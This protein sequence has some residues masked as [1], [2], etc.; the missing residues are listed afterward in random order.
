M[1]ETTTTSPVSSE[2]RP[3]HPYGGSQ[4]QALEACPC[5]RSKSSEHERTIAGTI[6]HKSVETG[7][8]DA[9]LSDEDAEGVAECL[10]LVEQRR[11]HFAQ[12][13]PPNTYMTE[14][15]ELY[16][17]IDDL[18]FDDTPY[19]S[20]GYVDRILLS[21]NEKHAEGFDWKF[22]YWAVEQAE[23]NL[24]ALVYSLG[25]FKRWPT[26]ETVR[27]WFRLPNIGQI[28]HVDLTRDQ[29]PAIYLRVQVV[30][31]RARKA[32]K[33]GNY[34][35]AEPRVPLCCFCANLGECTK[36]QPFI[37]KVAQK[38]HPVE[39]PAEINPSLLTDPHTTSQALRL[40]ALVKSWAEAYKSRLHDR[41][42]R[43]EADIPLGYHVEERRGHREV[44]DPQLFRQIAL[45][46][47][48]SEEKYNS[49]CGVPGFGDLEAVINEQTKKGKKAAITAFGK[50]LEDLHAVTRGDSFSY[51]KVSN[52][53]E[54]DKAN[55]QREPKTIKEK[56][57]P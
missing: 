30:V 14:F 44:T 23:N 51:L 10:D 6:G 34:E 48:I 20:A 26:V 4:L 39:F 38:Y 11:Q 45:R 53:R 43:G 32:R 24:Q 18:T 21:W 55:K 9:R 27:F 42:L 2:E 13:A 12:L 22:G 46:H 57:I 17:P 40:A 16:L 52:D 19:T 47:G 25:I 29:I 49:L 1:T 31:E 35:M 41:I 15:T 50:D 3:H 33:S 37:C 36:V 54:A 7:E 28:D 5:F 56:I 8:V